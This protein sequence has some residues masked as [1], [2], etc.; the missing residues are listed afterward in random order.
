MGQKDAILKL[1]NCGPLR[2]ARTALAVVSPMWIA[3]DYDYKIKEIEYRLKYAS[4]ERAVMF[5][6]R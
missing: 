4:E 3:F 6:D 2:E 5:A 1:I